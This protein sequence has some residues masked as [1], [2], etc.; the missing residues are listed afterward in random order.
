MSCL[1]PSLTALHTSS[2]KSQLLHSQVVSP[3]AGGTP[4]SRMGLIWESLKI[5]SIGGGG[6]HNDKIL[7]PMLRVFLCPPSVLITHTSYGYILDVDAI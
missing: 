7:E 4:F 1:R 2:Q 6:F 5:S 3:Q